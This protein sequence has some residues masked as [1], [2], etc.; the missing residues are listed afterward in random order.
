MLLTGD[1]SRRS[2]TLAPQAARKRPSRAPMSSS[3]PGVPQ[4]PHVERAGNPCGLPPRP[5]PGAKRPPAAKPATGRP[6]QLGEGGNVERGQTRSD[7]AAAVEHAEGPAVKRPSGKGP[8]RKPRRH[9][10][11]PRA[12][13]AWEGARIA[14]AWYSASV[15]RRPGAPGGDPPPGRTTAKKEQGCARQDQAFA[16]CRRP[17]FK[18]T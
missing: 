9:P 18:N 13:W 15:C 8:R 1:P 7:A 3:P 14:A 11:V 6:R 17:W 12:G 2:S 4:V 10:S 16:N 5:Y